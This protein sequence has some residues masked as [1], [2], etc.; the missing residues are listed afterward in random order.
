MSLNLT[1]SAKAKNTIILVCGCPRSGTTHV[2]KKL[3]DNIISLN[4]E[5]SMETIERTNISKDIFN[6]INEHFKNSSRTIRRTLFLCVVTLIRNK[7]Y[8]KDLW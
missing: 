5:I 1:P 7:F 3:P 8:M 2:A 6:I 4:S